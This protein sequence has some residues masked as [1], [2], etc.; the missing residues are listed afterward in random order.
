[1]HNNN[2]E[3]L[4][5]PAQLKHVCVLGK[6][7]ETRLILFSVLLNSTQHMVLGVSKGVLFI[8]VSSFERDLNIYKIMSHR[9]TRYIHTSGEI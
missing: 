8:E 1:M 4:P 2:V 5:S 6:A 9:L 7:W 3:M